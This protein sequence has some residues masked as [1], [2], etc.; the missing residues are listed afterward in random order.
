ML[1][2]P[3]QERACFRPC[4][5]QQ[6]GP[7]C[8]EALGRARE[9][10]GLRQEDRRERKEQYKQIQRQ[11]G[12]NWTRRRPN[13]AGSQDREGQRVVSKPSFWTGTQQMKAE[14]NNSQIENS[15]TQEKKRSSVRRR[16]TW[17]GP[18]AA[19]NSLRARGKEA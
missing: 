14:L 16:P 15:G 11:A 10:P 19:R 9:P 18:K 1:I 3:G 4:P 8:Q 17:Q 6:D 2:N 12:G 7:Y 5:Y 13:K